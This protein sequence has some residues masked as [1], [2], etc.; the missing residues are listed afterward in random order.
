MNSLLALIT[1]VLFIGCATELPKRARPPSVDADELKTGFWE[2]NSHYFSSDRLLTTPGWKLVKHEY[3]KKPSCVCAEDGKI[4]YEVLTV[5][6][7]KGEWFQIWQ[8]SRDEDDGG[9]C[10]GWVE[11]RNGNQVGEVFDSCLENKGPWYHKRTR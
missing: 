8:T 10:C 5:A 9:N 3:K 4:P 6:G 11:D 7:P 1:V 2:N